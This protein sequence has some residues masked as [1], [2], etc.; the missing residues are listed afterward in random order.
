MFSK[1][2][3]RETNLSGIFLTY[4]NALQLTARLVYT[5]KIKLSAGL[6]LAACCTAR[7][8]TLRAIHPGRVQ[9]C[10][11]T[12]T[13]AQI[14]FG[15]FATLDDYEN[16]ASHEVSENQRP[17]DRRDMQIII[18]HTSPTTEQPDI[19]CDN[20]QYGSRAKNCE[21][22]I[23]IFSELQTHALPA[24]FRFRHQGQ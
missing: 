18:K 24:L 23:F 6:I 5:R 1:K 12:K 19:A 13:G 10:A 11:T 9:S 20:R 16:Y 7:A 22:G 15:T 4:L 2:C 3:H 21:P 8:T 17:A 14:R